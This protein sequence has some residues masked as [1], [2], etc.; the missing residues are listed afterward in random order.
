MSTLVDRAVGSPQFSILVTALQYVDA[1]IPGSNLVQTL[2][3]NKTGLTVFAPT[4]D[5]FGALATDLGFE[6]D[7]SDADA[8]TAFLVGAVPAETLKAVLLYHVAAGVLDAATVTY[9]GEVKTIQ[10]G[11][12]T[13]DGLTLVDA[14]PDLANPTLIATDI[15]ASNGVI[16]AIDRVLLPIDLPGN[17]PAPQPEPEPQP[18]PA[19]LS[20]IAG[21]VASSGDGF[22]GN[23]G[24]FDMLL[25]AVKAAGLVDALNDDTASLTA[26][27]PTDDAFVGLSKALGYDG[28]DEA[29]AFGYLVEALTLLGG[30]DP[31]PLLTTVLTY[32]VAP[33]ALDANAVLSS[34]S[35]GTLAG[36]SFGV[37]GTSLVDADPDVPNPNIIATDI[38]ASNGIVHA[39]DGVLL[40]ADLLQSDGSN[41]VDFKIG[42][43]KGEKFATGRDND[44]IDGNGGRDFIYAGRGDDVAFG[45]DGND[46]IAGQRGDDLLNGDAGDDRIYGGSGSD[47]ISGGSGN[48]F[49]YGGWGK[50]VFVFSQGDGNN[51]VGDF[52]NGSDKIDLSDFGFSDYSELRDNIKAGFWRS[53]IDLGDT[54]ISVKGLSW[55]NISEDDF[56][57]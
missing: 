23:G 27:A 18:D 12:F 48:D 1:E 31:I 2:S 11:T 25:A 8:V 39:I 26:F 34:S 49:V 44:F 17:S 45:G 24:D 9:F 3:S 13:L 28:D 40:P 50:D 20:T 53:T 57:L 29:G 51:V 52:W 32:H 22:D 15:Y 35:I 19:P 54:E 41:D 43:D 30:G 37:D 42:T 56:I 46:L 7:P 21:I 55:W 16:H 33:G 38:Q 5:A 4:N 14:E 47:T 6:G 36:A 10:G